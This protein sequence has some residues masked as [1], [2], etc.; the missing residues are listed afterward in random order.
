M[1]FIVE[2]HNTFFLI[3]LPTVTKMSVL[4]KRSSTVMINNAGVY[5]LDW[6]G[7][8]A[9]W[10]YMYRIRLLQLTTLRILIATTPS[11]CGLEEEF[12]AYGS[13][14]TGSPCV[15][16]PF[17]LWPTKQNLNYLYG[18]AICDLPTHHRI[19]HFPKN[20]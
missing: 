15:T 9:Y 14:C 3:S 16:H 6:F 11:D 4:R 7:L 13:M 18:I 5:D 2:I 8:F 10:N 17:G 19:S 20:L 1:K 12:Q